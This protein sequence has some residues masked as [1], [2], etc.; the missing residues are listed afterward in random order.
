MSDLLDKT[1]AEAIR[2]ITGLDN[3][4]PRQAQEDLSREVESALD[5]EGGQVIGQ[6]ATGTGKAMALDTPI[7][8]PRGW[9]TMGRLRV[10]DEL[11]DEVGNVIR[12]L[13]V[14]KVRTGRPC[15][16]VRFSDGTHV[17][18]D[19]EHSWALTPNTDDLVNR[20]AIC[21]RAADFYEAEGLDKVNVLDIYEDTN[22]AVPLDVLAR[23]AGVSVRRFL[24]VDLLAR[25]ANTTLARA[26]SVE[27][28]A[29]QAGVTITE[30]VGLAGLARL[31]G[32]ELDHAMTPDDFT[33]VFETKVPHIVHVNPVDTLRKA[34]DI[35]R[36]TGLPD[37]VDRI[38]LK[39][40][41]IARRGSRVSLVPTRPLLL[42]HADLPID[43]WSMG[44]NLASQPDAETIPTRY[45][46]A[47]ATQRLRLL[48]GIMDT[49]GQ[50]HESD[51]EKH[52][53]CSLS[54]SSRS[55]MLSIIELLATLGIHG[56]TSSWGNRLGISFPAGD[57]R[58]FTDPERMKSLNDEPGL[59]RVEI[60]SVEPVESVPVRCIT[61]D[62]PSHLFLAGF[63]ALPTHNSLAYLVPA[64]LSAA[65]TER[66]TVVSTESLSLQAQL[67]DKD[68][69]VVAQAVKAT[70]GRDVK[71]A[72]LKGWSNY[73]CS[74]A[75]REAAHEI[76]GIDDGTPL[77]PA[78]VISLLHDKGTEEAELVAWALEQ[79]QDPAAP[80]DRHSYEGK[81]TGESWSKVSVTPAECPGA[82]RCP[83]GNV[84]K[85]A[86]AKEKAADADVVITNHT[87]LAVQ[88]AKNVPVIIGSKSLGRFDAI[89][90]DEAHGIPSQVRNQGSGEVSGRRIRSLVRKILSVVDIRHGAAGKDGKT[91]GQVLVD[92]GD[93]L[94]DRI[95]VILSQASNA[96]GSVRKLDENS[97]V[98]FAFSPAMST[99][100]SQAKGFVEQAAGAHREDMKVK[101]ALSLF[102]SVQADLDEAERFT[103]GVARWVE[104]PKDANAAAL[105]FST[106]NVSGPLRR[107]LWVS[108]VM[109]DDSLDDPEELKELGLDNEEKVVET[110][111]LSIVAVSAT[112]PT[113]FAY[114][115]GMSAPMH[116]YESPF[117]QAF[118]SSAVYIPRAVDQSDVDAL[119]SRWST[120]QRP[121][122]DTVRHHDWVKP[123]MGSLVEANGGHALVL[124]AK[125]ADG[126]EYARYLRENSGGNY[127]VL[128][129]W[130][131]IPLRQLVA[132]WREDPTSVLVGTRSLMTG[133]DAPGDTCSLVIIDRIPR[134]PSNPV[135]D[136][137]VEAIV[138][139]QKLDKWSA[140]RSVYVSDAA[141]LLSQAVGRLVR[142]SNDS[143]MV[144]VLDPRLLR[145][146]GTKFSYPE[147]TRQSYMRALGNMWGKRISRLDQ[148]QEFLH[149]QRKAQKQ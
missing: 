87:I 115:M 57:V 79:Y 116:N 55:L 34:V 86:I 16:R 134:S 90:M 113:G 129:Q 126:R 6:A 110:F 92:A 71:F 149:N 94:A 46:R 73:V 66:R 89:I 95:D 136:A 100:I 33:E 58:V 40:R 49:I 112:L 30:A 140:D 75:A 103:P 85:A 47:S 83:F 17:V 142:S 138:D 107:N 106:V 23:A 91:E 13:V 64:A 51:D 104:A 147:P 111:P 48:Q 45:L 54:H 141:L 109:D 69:P 12:V 43:P 59:R 67:I 108:P 50:V 19:A 38:V 117:S 119:S 10:G 148:A 27:A 118:S 135:D 68:A 56:R 130:S 145:R 32:N 3:A 93:A 124:S 24:P 123:I 72:V 81:T 15:Y 61:V 14:H 78:Q 74:P 139:A 128:D 125:A 137:R 60:V 7:P 131:G 37:D 146:S 101:R 88:A 31:S 121:K 102:D 99:W 53:T 127:V 98:T 11:F 8:T 132:Q 44:R 1:M 39:T 143:G 22:G 80:G 35:I 144:A 20:I 41:E 21:N 4:A 9:T 77:S 18:V 84:C 122:F 62:S 105:K 36:Q 97:S 65:E 70:T 5:S 25:A 29:R 120:Q 96:D 76:L 82:K 114:D 133:V 63:S 42:P 2:I 52:T 26:G 28:L